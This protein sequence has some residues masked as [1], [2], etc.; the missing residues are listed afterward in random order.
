MR[1]MANPAARSQPAAH[2][3]VRDEIEVLPDPPP[4]QEPDQDW[5]EK[6]PA[7]LKPSPKL[8]MFMNKR[9]LML[10][11][12]VF[13]NFTN[14]VSWIS[15]S[16]VANFVNAFYGEQT[17]AWL[18]LI[19]M[20]MA[21]PLSFA[22]MWIGT[23]GSVTTIFLCGAVPNFLGSLVRFLSS[24]SASEQSYRYHIALTG[25][26]LA[27][28]SYPFIMY[29]PSKVSNAWFPPSQRAI[30]TTIGVMS[31]PAGVMVANLVAPIIVRASTDVP[32]L[33][34]VLFG[35]C[36]FA[37]A[38]VLFTIS[39][40]IPKENKMADMKD[41]TY[42]ESIGRC[43]STPTYIIIFFTLGGGIGMFNS[44]YTMMFS[45]MCPAGHNN[46]IAGICAAVMIGAGI[47][48][49][50]V[51]SILV[52]KYKC[53]KEV[54]IVSIIGASFFGIGFIWMTIVS[55]SLGV[56]GLFICAFLLG[57][58]GMA[59]YPVGLELAVECTYPAA[60]EVSSGYIVILGQVFSV[61]FVIILKGFSNQLSAEETQLGSG[62]CKVDVSDNINVPY[63]YFVGLIIMSVLASLLGVAILFIKPVYLRTATDN[64]FHV[65]EK[66]MDAFIDM[67][68]KATDTT[69][70]DKF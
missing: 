21:V 7:A 30:A 5:E 52:D 48:G 24:I 51:A 25:Q 45:L 33:N 60:V 36:T 39:G 15:Y 66:E 23:A 32:L 10:M 58:F 6:T 64:R 35:A 65:A 50:T 37:L 61:I 53:Y 43:F 70:V 49:A 27:A 22:S 59:A 55:G 12:V 19:Y 16:P 31:N 57:M 38:T 1:N 8:T 44:L 68:A 3:L 47:I 2:V 17:A 18:S 9:W 63:D 42:E 46:D 14:T 40:R 56:A 4:N 11:L 67:Y 13:I 20:A 28:V 29:L 41:Q 54:M 69:F 62:A 34:S 26:A